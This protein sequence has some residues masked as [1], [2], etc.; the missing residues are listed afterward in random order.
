[1]LRLT[2]AIGRESVGKNVF[3]SCPRG[4]RGL[5]F[6]LNV[7]DEQTRQ[8]EKGTNNSPDEA[9]AAHYHMIARRCQDDT[10]K[11]EKKRNEFAQ[12]KERC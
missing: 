12:T 7:L 3:V 9:I 10:H 4:I 11:L 8:W 5:E 6:L 1:M 2:R